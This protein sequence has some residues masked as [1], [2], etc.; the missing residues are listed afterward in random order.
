MTI[1]QKILEI[2]EFYKAPEPSITAVRDAITAYYRVMGIQDFRCGVSTPTDPPG[3]GLDFI[4]EVC[5][6]R[7][8][9]LIEA[10]GFGLRRYDGGKGQ[11]AYF[12]LLKDTITE[13]RLLVLKAGVEAEVQWQVLAGKMTQAR[14]SKLQ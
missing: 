1:T 13:E 11:N 10:A 4:P 7:L 14:C 8:A 2:M 3:I 12:L 9:E 6:E 5:R